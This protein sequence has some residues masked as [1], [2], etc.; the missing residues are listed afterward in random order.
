LVIGEVV[1]FAEPSRLGEQF[2]GFDFSNDSASRAG[3]NAK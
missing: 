1:R 2:S 3:E